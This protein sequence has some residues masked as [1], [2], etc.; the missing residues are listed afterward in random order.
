[1]RRAYADALVGWRDA[2][3]ACRLML[4]DVMQ[5]A[6]GR[7][8]IVPPAQYIYL[9]SPYGLHNIRGLGRAP[10]AGEPWNFVTNWLVAGPFP[11]EWDG[12]SKTTPT[13]FDRAYAPEAKFDS[14]ATFDTVDG[15]GPWR[16][17]DTDLTGRLDFLR[18]FATTEN[19][20]GYARCR[21]IAP[22]DMD[23]TFSL[24]SNDGAR[25]WVNGQDVFAW[26]SVAQGG[27]GA[28]PHQNEFPVHLKAGENVVLVK[29]ENLGANWQLYL[30]A[31]DPTRV[32]RFQAP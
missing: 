1:M 10:K 15:P 26:S 6:E 24:G 20:V 9:R 29:V 8:A 19:V 18:H 12:A 5:F 27:R 21:V 23:T 17:V 13:G 3:R 2:L 32:L 4:N 22:T 16:Y 28:Q 11:L 30:S 25:V 14:C 7:R 31:N